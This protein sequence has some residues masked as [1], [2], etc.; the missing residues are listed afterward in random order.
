MPRHII[1][2]QDF[3]NRENIEKLLNRAEEFRSALDKPSGKN[4]FLDLFP[5]KILLNIFY[6]PSTRT[7][8]SFAIAALRLGM[9]VEGTENAKEFSS[10][11]KGETLED[12][13]RVMSEY[14]PDVIVLRHPEK[15]AAE[16]AALVSQVPIINGGDGAGQHPTQALLDLFAIRREV[17]RLDN[18]VVVMGGDL[19]FGRTVRSLCYL[20]AKYQNNQIRFVSPPQ[21]RMADDIKAY[22]NRHNTL[23]TELTD[24][25]KALSNADI[26]YWTRIQKEHLGDNIDYD[27][28]SKVYEINEKSLGWLKPQARIFHPLPRVNE[29]A[30]AVDN[31]K[32]AAYFRQAGY[33]VPVR[34]ALIEWVLQGD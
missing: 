3:Q 23:Y 4:Q 10:A 25:K 6:Q 17:G 5:G 12:S 16:K 27:E 28:V 7:R 22:L 19:R 29:I 31:S 34:M 26:V 15:G 9:R 2:S 32:H 21:L 13:I 14:H 30:P 24:L 1:Q 18:L 20:L 11:I 33:G 8:L